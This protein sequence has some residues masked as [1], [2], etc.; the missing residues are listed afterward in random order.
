MPSEKTVQPY[1]ITM[2]W[3]QSHLSFSLLRS[4]ILCIRGS[5]SSYHHPICPSEAPIDVIA[6]E[7]RV[8][9]S[10]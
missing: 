4:A 5:R 3:I 9:T 2:G 10:W 6:S 8:A 1:S 7:G